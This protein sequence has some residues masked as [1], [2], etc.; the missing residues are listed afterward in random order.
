M[1]KKYSSPYE[2]DGRLPLK[3]A[4]PLGMQHVLAMFIGNLTAPI[5]I[6]GVCGVASGSPIHVT[7]LSNAMFIAGIVTL[8][9]LV[10]N[11]ADLLCISVFSHI[12]P[13]FRICFGEKKTPSGICSINE[14]L[15]QTGFLC[16]SADDERCYPPFPIQSVCQTA[17]GVL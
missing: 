9:Q 12:K 4:I 10:R 8:F 13:P 11:L 3:T 14:P 7:I 6:L 17:P 16:V 1:K 15:P 2:L 5:V